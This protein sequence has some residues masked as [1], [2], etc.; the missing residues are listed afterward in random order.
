MYIPAFA[1]ARVECFSIQNERRS[2]QIPLFREPRAAAGV[3][4]PD[5]D[6]KNPESLK[7]LEKV[8]Q[9]RPTSYF[10][11]CNPKPGVPREEKRKLENCVITPFKWGMAMSG[12]QKKFERSRL[13]L[14]RIFH[15]SW[16]INRQTHR[17][18][19]RGHWY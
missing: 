6:I 3:S 8:A 9:M 19:K 5:G 7:E 1:W 11:R 13:F 17:N 14:W 18:T 12:G 10:C 4:F 16:F 15:R 2:P